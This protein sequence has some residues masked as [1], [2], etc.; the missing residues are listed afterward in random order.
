MKTVGIISLGCCKNLV[1]SELLL[2]YFKDSNYTV[3]TQPETADVII[4]NTCGF[5]LD[6]KK[7][8]LDM[9][10]E[11]AK[12]KKKLV[13]TGCLVQRYYK[14][15]KK[16]LPEADLLVKI[17]DYPHL[18]DKVIQID[19]RFKKITDGIWYYNRVIPYNGYSAYLK[20]AEGCS[21]HCSY[22]AIPLIRGELKSRRIKDIM[23]E[24]KYLATR[25]IK[26]LVV[27]AQ[28]TT[29]YGLDIYGKVKIVDLLKQLL[30]IKDFQFIRLLYLYPDEIDDDLIQ[31]IKNEKRIAP[32]FDIPIQHSEDRILKAM[33]RRGSK[34]FL[35][36]KNKKIRKEIPNAI[37]RTTIMVGFPGET[38]EDFDN[39]I[40]FIKEVKFDHLGVFAY[41]REEDTP[42]FNMKDQISDEIKTKRVDDVMIAQHY[43][44][45]EKNESHIG[46]IM[47]GIVIKRTNR[48]YYLR[49]YYNAPDEIDGNILF[50]SRRR[51]KVGDVVKVEIT[52][53]TPYDLY[54][55]FVKTVDFKKQ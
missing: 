1:D 41:S 35:L 46:E 37:L 44:S 21:N 27:I 2:G 17:S 6:A 26:E 3:V 18:Y 42:S 43:I 36:N 16:E 5:I 13:I 24:A 31:L 8:S 39:L 53:S 22:C 33:N 55:E 50:N 15:L 45:K 25:N 40:D 49:S 9:I 47:T 10:F 7:E 23:I 11:M 29:K 30:E 38:Q 4:I 51:L 48:Y 28:D 14:E 12:Y 54:G 34:Q 19:K 52:N 20:I 32:Y